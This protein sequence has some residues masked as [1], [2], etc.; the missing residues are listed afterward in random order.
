MRYFTNPMLE[1]HKVNGPAYIKDDDSSIWAWW[2]NGT[3]H[4]YYGP[5]N[6]T[7]IWCIHHTRIK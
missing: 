3:R 5:Q 7:N 4:R 2:L 1:I 6:Y